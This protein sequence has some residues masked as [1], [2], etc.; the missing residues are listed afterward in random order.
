MLMKK[1]VKH[2]TFLHVVLRFA[3]FHHLAVCVY[4]QVLICAF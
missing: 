2:E 4:I 1:Y 3:Q